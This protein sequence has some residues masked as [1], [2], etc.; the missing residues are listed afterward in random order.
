[1]LLSGSRM[2][3][4]VKYAVSVVC[5]CLAVL[6][7]RSLLAYFPEERVSEIPGFDASA[8]ESAGNYALARAEED[9]K[10]R[11]SSLVYGEFGIKPLTVDIKIDWDGE[12]AVIE[13]IKVVLDDAGTVPRVKEYLESALGGEICV[14][15]G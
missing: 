15:A 1:M 8:A 10:N 5:L 12:G 2:E 13:S 3:K 14:V 11:I 6:P 9:C 7:L 4:Y